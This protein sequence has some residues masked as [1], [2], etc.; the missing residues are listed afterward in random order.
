[1]RV[2]IRVKVAQL[3]GGLFGG[4]NLVAALWVRIYP[5]VADLISLQRNDLQNGL[6]RNRLQNNP[7]EYARGFNPAAKL[8]T[9]R[10]GQNNPLADLVRCAKSFPGKGIKSAPN[11]SSL[12]E[13][14]G[15]YAEA[16]SPLLQQGGRTRAWGCRLSYRLGRLEKI[17][18]I[19]KSPCLGIS[20]TAKIRSQLL[21]TEEPEGC[22]VSGV[23]K[24]NALS[25]AVVEA[26]RFGSQPIAS[27]LTHGPKPCARGTS[28]HPSEVKT[29][30]PARKLGR[31]TLASLA[32]GLTDIATCPKPS[33]FP[34]VGAGGEDGNPPGMSAIR[35]GL[36]FQQP[37]CPCVGLERLGASPGPKS[38]SPDLAR[39]AAPHPSADTMARSAA[40]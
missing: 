12:R 27:S 19:E 11:P 17:G 34:C 28:P 6:L 30:S 22:E 38:T 15:E 10:M 8:G 14:E 9:W 26:T 33:R 37:P 16:P 25:P 21:T 18:P 24:G 35:W 23:W 1:V 13:E 32:A 4:F 5:Y 29:Q 3:W 36:M 7:P 40:L 39:F 31:E 20:F 2:N